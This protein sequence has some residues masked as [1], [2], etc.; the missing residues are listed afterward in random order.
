MVPLK[1]HTE[2]VHALFDILYLGNGLQDM[3]ALAE[4]H[5]LRPIHL[6]DINY[7][8]IAIS[9]RA[10]LVRAHISEANGQA[11][12]NDSETIRMKKHNVLNDINRHRSAFVAQDVD[13]PSIFWLLC[14][15]R[16]K[17]AFVGYIICPTRP[18]VTDEEL[19]M[20]THLAYAI[21]IEMQKSNMFSY[22]TGLKYSYFFNNLIEGRFESTEI[23]Q[24]RLEVLDKK[25]YPFIHILC[26]SAPDSVNRNDFKKPVVEKARSCFRNCISTTYHNNL[27]LLVSE[28]TTFS[29][30]ENMFA[31]FFSFIQTHGLCAG[32]SQEFFD[33]VN[34]PAHYRSALQALEIGLEMK[35]GQRI[36]FSE[37]LLFYQLLHSV[38][39]NQLSAIHYHIYDQIKEHDRLYNT[40]F[41][42]TIR[43][44][45]DYDRN[46]TQAAAALHIHRTT[47]F[48]RIKKIEELWNISFTNCKT[49]F[50]MEVSFRIDDF[51]RLG[52][53]NAPGDEQN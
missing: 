20:M 31:D 18:D 46:S 39:P 35:L 34:T 19:E 15:V 13:Y 44:F 7:N 2:F 16:I 33:I 11:F 25:V 21:S 38:D 26:I 43:A 47:F 36:F 28:K 5:L 41:L 4:T 27:V 49:L 1:D 12:L 37:E 29:G 32:V 40:D 42:P 50:L 48:Y 24:S 17:N 6:Y 14:A 45:L 51:L 3:L 10:E 53:L 9:P 22:K 23:I 30:I 52:P 8:L